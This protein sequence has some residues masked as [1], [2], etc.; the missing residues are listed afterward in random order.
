VNFLKQCPEVGKLVTTE[1]RTTLQA[2][3]L[4]HADFQ[5]AATAIF[6]LNQETQSKLAEFLTSRKFPL[7]TQFDVGLHIRSGDKI[8]KGEM[9]EVSVDTYFLAL[10]TIA[11]K[12]KKQKLNVFVMTDNTTLFQKLSAKCP[13]GWMLYTLQEE[14]AYTRLGHNQAAFNLMPA[15]VRNQSYIQFLAELEIMKRMPHLVV[16]FTSHIGRWLSITNTVAK[17]EDI[18]SLD[19]VDWDF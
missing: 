10:E 18:V 5:R 11:K 7:Q 4:T 3:N 8:T 19:E 15:R 1:M 17:R 16:T 12:L 6:Q 14:Y 9:Q 2:L 13:R